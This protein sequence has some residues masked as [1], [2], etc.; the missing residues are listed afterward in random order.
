MIDRQPQ[1]ITYDQ[2]QMIAKNA[3][4]LV[5][6][7]SA[8]ATSDGAA[9]QEEALHLMDRSPVWHFAGNTLIKQSTGRHGRTLADKDASAALISQSLIA[10]VDVPPPSVAG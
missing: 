10:N 6:A 5:F 4:T 8:A 3:V 1:K 2:S 7:L 9:T